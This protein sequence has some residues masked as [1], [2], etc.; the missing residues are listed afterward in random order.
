MNFLAPSVSGAEVVAQCPDVLKKDAACCVTYGSLEF[1]YLCP[2][3]KE[4]HRKV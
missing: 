2:N 4:A 3:L 1:Q